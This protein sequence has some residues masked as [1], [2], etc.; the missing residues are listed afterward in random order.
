MVVIEE[1]ETQVITVNGP[2]GE[3]GGGLRVSV[4]VEMLKEM[5][6]MRNELM[7]SEIRN[8]Q[9]ILE[10]QDREQQLLV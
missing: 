9:T 6:L 5:N 10:M 7:E 2:G 8:Q 3:F 4:A 1:T